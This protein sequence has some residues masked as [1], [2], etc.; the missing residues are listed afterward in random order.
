[1][2]GCGGGDSAVQSRSMG[3][4]SGGTHT[5]THTHTQRNVH[6]NVVPTL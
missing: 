4:V 5:G 6:A 3:G 1:M 2:S